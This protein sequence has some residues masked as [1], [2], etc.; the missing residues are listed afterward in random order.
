MNKLNRYAHLFITWKYDKISRGKI[1]CRERT[2]RRALEIDTVKTEFSRCG[3]CKYSCGTTIR[4][5]D[6]RARYFETI[7]S[8]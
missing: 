6:P 3:I 5:Y 8:R 7:Y 1:L 2:R 4:S